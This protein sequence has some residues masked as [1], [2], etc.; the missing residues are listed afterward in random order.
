MC[1]S[2][3]VTHVPFSVCCSFVVFYYRI[4]DNVD[5]ME[6]NVEQAHGE[7]LKY[8][9]SVSSDRWLM[10]K[11]FLVLIVFFIVFVLLA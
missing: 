6:Q 11:V 4:D 9:S 2:V 3:F 1:R 7:L 5:E 10:I 8:F